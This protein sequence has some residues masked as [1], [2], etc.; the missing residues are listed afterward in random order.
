MDDARP[1]A[2]SRLR[3]GRGLLAALAVLVVLALVATLI[4]IVRDDGDD[5]D[6]V[7][8]RGELFTLAATSGTVTRASKPSGGLELSLSA[9]GTRVLMFS[10]RPARTSRAIPLDTLVGQWAT[11]GF[12][13][14]PPNAVLALSEDSSQEMAAVEISAPR[15]KGGTVTFTLAPL[16]GG[17][18]EQGIFDRLRQG[19]AGEKEVRLGPHF[20]F[21]DPSGPDAPASSDGSAQYGCG[22]TGDIE[23]S[24]FFN[25]PDGEVIQYQALSRKDAP[26]LY[27]VV[28]DQYGDTGDA[29]TFAVPGIGALKP[30][31]GNH[32]GS[33]P[34]DGF[35]ARVCAKGMP[36]TKAAD[37]AA[38]ADGPGG[39]VI[40]EL[41]ASG[42]PFDHAGWLTADGRELNVADY[43]ELHKRIGAQF[44]GDGDKTFALPDYQLPKVEH[45][46]ADAAQPKTRICVHGETWTPASGERDLSQ[47]TVSDCALGAIRLFAGGDLPQGY[48]PP[49]GQILGQNALPQLFAAIGNL[50]SQTTFGLPDVDDPK[51][52]L[53]WGMCAVGYFPSEWDNGDRLPPGGL[54]PR[55]LTTGPVN[56][57]PCG[58]Y[59]SGSDKNLDIGFPRAAFVDNDF[60]PQDGSYWDEPAVLADERN[61]PAQPISFQ[62]IPYTGDCPERQP[63][64]LKRDSPVYNVSFELTLTPTESGGLTGTYKG[65]DEDSQVTWWLVFDEGSD[66][67]GKI[68]A[69]TIATNSLSA[70]VTKTRDVPFE[71]SIGY[72]DLISGVGQG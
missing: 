14:D 63:V 62:V 51:D 10:D 1:D 37:P 48:W 27:A 35:R 54:N 26:D 25:V 6:G 24:V 20:V 22:T 31:S 30:G 53:R 3:R 18:G 32:P 59:G 23:F 71:F 8:A 70:P 72:K 29:G 61:R 40:G 7:S 57:R 43:Q 12:K 4:L 17:A 46:D 65:T 60:F 19:T 56:Y 55:P 15:R 44:G 49:Q 16:R 13:D 9:A 41:R 52:G 34:E 64:L 11:L 39:C 5:S 58:P 67:K 50:Y 42:V 38:V 68:T 47:P 45:P 21:I 36:P 33:F 2:P 69:L 28:G 66:S